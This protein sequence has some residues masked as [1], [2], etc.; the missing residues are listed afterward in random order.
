M[1]I[2][3]ATAGNVQAINEL[4]Q[5][6]WRAHYPG[7]ISEE[8]IEFM[9]SSMYSIDS[10][11]MQMAKGHSF[12]M[13]EEG[14]TLLGYLSYHSEEDGSYFLNKL[15][16]DVRLQRKNT[17]GQLLQACLLACKKDKKIRLQVNRKNFKAINFY[18]KMGFVIE[19]TG[20]FDIG[21][22][23]FMNDFIMVKEII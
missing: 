18:F 23:Y 11:T 16:V 2:R 12:L 6:I 19:A 20:D 14:N 4:A 10:L 8:Q 22:G 3:K 7:I 13:A 15:Y 1:Q 9:L 17:G 5:H 21:N